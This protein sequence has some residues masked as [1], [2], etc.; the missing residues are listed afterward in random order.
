MIDGLLSLNE[1]S[2]DF[3]FFF[4]F[5]PTAISGNSRWLV[6][7]CEILKKS[8]R[9]VVTI[10]ASR[11]IILKVCK[12]VLSFFVVAFRL[13]ESQICT[14]LPLVLIKVA[15]FTPKMKAINLNINFQVR[16]R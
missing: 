1:P 3:C 16:T 7:V 13:L 2:K 8:K 14:F 9:S 15:F 12:I 10:V 4:L 11:I 5:Y 6:H